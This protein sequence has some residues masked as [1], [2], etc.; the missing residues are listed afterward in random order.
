MDVVEQRLFCLQLIEGSDGMKTYENA[1]TGDTSHKSLY[2]YH[3][4]ILLIKH[5]DL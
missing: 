2:Q 1:L 5:R 3:D 4:K